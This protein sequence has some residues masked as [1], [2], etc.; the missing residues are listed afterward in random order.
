VWRAIKKTATHWDDL[1]PGDSL[2]ALCHFR[3]HGG[4]EEDKQGRS[5]TNVW[6]AIKKTA[7]HWDDLSPGDALQALARAIQQNDD[8]QSANLDGEVYRICSF[9]ASRTASANPFRVPIEKD[10]QPR[11][12]K[13]NPLLTVQN[14]SRRFGELNCAASCLSMEAIEQLSQQQEQTPE[15]LFEGCEQG[16]GKTVYGLSSISCVRGES[17][18]ESGWSAGL[19]TQTITSLFFC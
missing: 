7:T 17:S 3:A 19:E 6:Q 1:S 18:G 2:Q 8:P 12:R 5:K 9:P 11:Y 13:P 4:E 14:V 15:K 10:E 16:G